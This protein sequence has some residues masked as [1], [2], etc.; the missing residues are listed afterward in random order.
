VFVLLICVAVVFAQ[1]TTTTGS[2]GSGLGPRKCQAPTGCAIYDD[3]GVKTGEQCG[4]CFGGLEGNQDSLDTT[5]GNL[6]LYCSDSGTAC[7]AST[8]SA[9]RICQAITVAGRGE[10]CKATNTYCCDSKYGIGCLPKEGVCG[11]GSVFDAAMACAQSAENDLTGSPLFGCI[12]NEC[13]SGKCNS[14]T[15]PNCVP[16]AASPGTPGVPVVPTAF[17]NTLVFPTI[18]SSRLAIGAECT[19]ATGLTP[20]VWNAECTSDN[21]QI[22]PKYHCI[23]VGTGA[24]GEPCN[25]GGYVCDGELSCAISSGKPVC[26][27][28]VSVGATCTPPGGC[29]TTTFTSICVCDSAGTGTG[30][31]VGT[32]HGVKATEAYQKYTA[33]V[34]NNGCGLIGTPYYESC[35]DLHCASE[36]QSFAC[37]ESP[38]PIKKTLKADNTGLKCQCGGGGGGSSASTVAL[39]GAAL[40]ASVA[41]MLLY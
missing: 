29:D 30:I 34:Q 1:T 37:A 38:S 7:L 20:C 23:A 2:A 25:L 27:T 35:V 6:N 36:Y 17:C 11:S 31:C 26:T 13:V 16:A 9:F 15:G 28:P 18:A 8:G 33:C 22:A 4:S 14:T 21:A 10:P 24:V 12:Q 40:V 41:A 5:T 3:V 39:V 19:N 32:N